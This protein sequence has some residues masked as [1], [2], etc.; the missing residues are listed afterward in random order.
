MLEEIGVTCNP[1][2]VQKNMAEACGMS[3]NMVQGIAKGRDR[4]IKILS[5][6][7]TTNKGIA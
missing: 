1:S 6:Y 4:R 7:K 3:K 5:P 2:K